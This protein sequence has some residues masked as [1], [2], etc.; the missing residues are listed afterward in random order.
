MQVATVDVGSEPKLIR[1]E[2]YKCILGSILMK[3]EMRGNA[4]L[5]E[6]VT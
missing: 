6:K 4:T 3:K 1:L 5:I 2:K